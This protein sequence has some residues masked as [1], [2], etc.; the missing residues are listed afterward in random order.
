MLIPRPEAPTTPV[1]SPAAI[2][3]AIDVDDRMHLGNGCSAACPV[4]T[5]GA[6][7]LKTCTLTGGHYG[8]HKCPVGHTWL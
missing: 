2:L 6:P 4:K 7:C 8:P 1:Q 3:P 5:D